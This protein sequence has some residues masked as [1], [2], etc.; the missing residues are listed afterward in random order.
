MTMTITSA[1]DA[2][3]ARPVRKNRKADPDK[4]RELASQGKSRVEIAKSLG[5]C[6]SVVSRCCA[7]HGIHLLKFFGVGQP[8]SPFWEINDAVLAELVKTHTASQ[9]AQKLGVTKNAAIGR[10]RRLGLI[11][12]GSPNASKPIRQPIEFPP[13]GRCVYPIGDIRNPDFHF[14]GERTG[15]LMEPYCST[16]HRLCYRPAPVME[17]A[18]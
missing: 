12:A 3:R 15:A 7:R 6:V 10:A 11:W 8:V 18:A 9:A 16:H 2:A 4:V 1:D 14:C 17:E 5:C 13:N